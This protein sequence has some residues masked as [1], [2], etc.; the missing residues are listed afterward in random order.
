MTI[1]EAHIAFKLELDKTSSLELPA[2][3]SEEI[4]FWLDNAQRKFVKT[5]YSGINFK[6]ESFEQSQKRIDDLRTLVVQEELSLTNSTFRDNTYIAD[7]TTLTKPYWF[8]LSEEVKIA[9]L[10]LTNSLTTVAVNAVV[11]T[12]MYKVVDGYLKYMSNYLYED[13]YYMGS[14]ID[15]YTYTN[16]EGGG[17]LVLLGSSIEPV[18]EANANTFT[19]LLQNP[20]SEHILHYEKASPLRLFLG[21]TVELITDG[22]YGLMSY[23]LR[24][25]KKPRI[26]TSLAT[27]RVDAQ[28]LSNYDYIVSINTLTYNGD[29]YQVGDI[30]I[31]LGGTST[32][33]GGGTATIYGSFELP[34][35]THDEV[36]RLAVN[37]AL[38]NIEQPRYQSHANEVVTME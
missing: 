34:E 28:T 4:D 29:I 14:Y 32:I 38:E 20:Y 18:K 21:N 7:L 31:G 33:T 24:Y 25:L 2:Y 27:T 37:M 22:N 10:S 17:R 16:T 26:I 19:T 13:Q 8:T 23:Y 1:S 9:Y 5:R 3:E 35:H 30:I 12:N 11:T 15:N 6:G 36:V